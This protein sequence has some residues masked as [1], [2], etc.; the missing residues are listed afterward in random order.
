MSTWAG[1]ILA[2]GKGTRMKSRIPKVLHTILGKPLLSYSIQTL[3]KLRSNHAA[4]N[5]TFFVNVFK[6]LT[7][8]T[9]GKFCQNP[10][11]YTH[12]KLCLNQKDLKKGIASSRFLRASIVN[13]SVAII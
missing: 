2:A 1:L 12:T 3:T 8:S 5:R 6:L 13:P 4:K 9:Y 11:N 10:K 7:N